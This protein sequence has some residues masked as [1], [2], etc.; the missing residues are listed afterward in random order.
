MSD[1]AK[2]PNAPSYVTYFLNQD[3]PKIA[4]PRLTWAPILQKGRK[5]ENISSGNKN[6][7]SE[8]FCIIKTHS[9]LAWIFGRQG[10]D[11][12][13]NFHTPTKEH[14]ADLT[15]KRIRANIKD[16]LSYKVKLDGPNMMVIAPDRDL[17]SYKLDH[18]IRTHDNMSAFGLFEEILDKIQGTSSKSLRNLVF[19]CHGIRGELFI[20]GKHRQSQAL[21]KRNADLFKKL[22]GKVETVWMLSCDTCIDKEFMETFTSNSGAYL[23]GATFRNPQKL[24]NLEKGEIEFHSVSMPKVMDKTKKDIYIGEFIGR[25]SKDSYLSQAKA[26]AHFTPV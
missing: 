12:L 20:F 15:S 5:K 25:M 22:S 17:T 4:V 24:K 1:F 21:K 13:L 23:V 8:N 9:E 19:Q 3:P 14:L 11:A 16:H 7:V 2:P 10:G 26:L 18:V 6:A